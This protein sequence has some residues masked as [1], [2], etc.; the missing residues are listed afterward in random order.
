LRW[1]WMCIANTSVADRFVEPV[2]SNAGECGFET[3]GVVLKAVDNRRKQG[4]AEM[5]RDVAQQLRWGVNG[6]RRRRG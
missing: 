3:V 5:M 1:S 4:R 2:G 6:G